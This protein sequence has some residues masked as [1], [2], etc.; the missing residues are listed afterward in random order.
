MIAAVFGRIPAIFGRKTKFFF[1][2]L[3]SIFEDS[4]P[5]ERTLRE[6]CSNLDASPGFTEQV[7]QY[8]GEKVKSKLLHFLHTSYKNVLLLH[9]IKK[10]ATLLIIK[11]D[12][13]NRLPQLKKSS[14]TWWWMRFAS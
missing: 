10:I 13:F 5:C 1:R 4:L 6:W 12:F 14:L 2:Y 11:L 7:F 8:L 9:W 3:R